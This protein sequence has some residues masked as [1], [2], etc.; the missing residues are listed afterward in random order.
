MLYVHFDSKIMNEPEH[1]I[2]L[3]VVL[4]NADFELFQ[5]QG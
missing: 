4:L 2:L 1:R 5:F 3:N